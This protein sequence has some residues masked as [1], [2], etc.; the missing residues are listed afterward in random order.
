MSSE[1]CTKEGV[2][3][4]EDGEDEGGMCRG[5][6]IETEGLGF[7]LVAIGRGSPYSSAVLTEM[8]FASA[9]SHF[10]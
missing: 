1:P 6:A 8:G 10:H 5:D 3:G 9:N 2:E 4:G 7:N